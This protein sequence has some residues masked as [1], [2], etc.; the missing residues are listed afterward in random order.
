MRL[1]LVVWVTKMIVDVLLLVI[2]AN[3]AGR[4]R[5]GIVLFSPLTFLNDKIGLSQTQFNLLISNREKIKRMRYVP[6]II[7]KI[8]AG[9]PPPW[10]V[11]LLHDFRVGER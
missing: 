8:F 6:I 9:F 7:R 11:G 10:R 5:C 3:L 2:G 4:L 1:N